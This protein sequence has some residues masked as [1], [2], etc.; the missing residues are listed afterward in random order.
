MEKFI[1]LTAIPANDSVGPIDYINPKMIIGMTRNENENYTAIFTNKW[2]YK[3][4]E[5][6]EEILDKIQNL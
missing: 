5:T 3:V 4:T 6:P 2:M 1:K